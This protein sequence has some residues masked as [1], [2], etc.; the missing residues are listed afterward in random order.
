MISIKPEL[1]YTLDDLNEEKKPVRLNIELIT[2]VALKDVDNFSAEFV[3][4]IKK[5]QVNEMD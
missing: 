4:L 2:D 3:T 5:Y 1:Q